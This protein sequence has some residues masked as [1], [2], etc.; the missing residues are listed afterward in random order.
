M[1][2][3]FSFFRE[4]DRALLL[5]VLA[6]LA[7]SAV[8][9]TPNI[10]DKCELSTDC[11]IRG[12][13]LCDTS[14]PGG[15]CTIFNC[16]TDSCPDYAACVLF[17]AAVQGCGYDDRSFS[18]TGR[19]FCMAQ[20][21]SDSDCRDGYMC[22]DP[23]QP[24]WS[25]LIIDDDQSQRVCIVRPDDGVVGPNASV[26]TVDAAV[27]SPS[28]PGYDASF[29]PNDAS[30][31]TGVS[32]DTGVDTGSDTGTDSGSDTGPDAADAAVD[33]ADAGIDAGADA[34]DAGA[35]DAPAG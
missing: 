23:R 25:A 29:S 21:H 33:A 2:R 15:Y 28:A 16:K 14:Q 30:F 5:G 19:S 24:P 10:G 13:R 27:C 8:G 4:P 18:R 3:F 6:A 7:F 22:T 35:P 11:S 1:R 31:D 32:I 20:C 34:A 26:A 12:D 17:Q 9:C